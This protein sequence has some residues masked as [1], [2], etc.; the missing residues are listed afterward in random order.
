MCKCAISSIF[1]GKAIC[2]LCDLEQLLTRI[3][4]SQISPSSPT[5]A[6]YSGE[7]RLRVRVPGLGFGVSEGGA[8][9]PAG[10]RGR[11]GG[12]RPAVGARVGQGSMA[13]ALAV[14]GGGG[15]GWRRGRS[16]GAC[17]GGG[18]ARRREGQH[19]GG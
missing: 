16:A 7:F 5:L 8:A 13:A 12:G 4:S 14:G 9:V 2:Y 3:F 19:A 1:L 15:G 6:S 18:G 10:P 17:R 11:A